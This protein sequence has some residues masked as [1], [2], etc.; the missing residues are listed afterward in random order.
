MAENVVVGA[1]F[2][3]FVASQDPQVIQQITG[4]KAES[5]PSLDSIVKELHGISKSFAESPERR[6][7]R[8]LAEQCANR[9]WSISDFKTVVTAVMKGASYVWE[10]IVTAFY[11]CWDVLSI[12]ANGVWTAIKEVFGFCKSALTAVITPV[13]STVGGWLNALSEVGGAVARFLHLW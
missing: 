7:V 6:K 2:E 1:V 10:A 4:Q 8:A 9:S 5:S 12:I 13:I 11:F 3:N